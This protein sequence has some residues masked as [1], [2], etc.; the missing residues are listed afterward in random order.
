MKKS[1][2][3]LL[4]TM[5]D[6]RCAETALTTFLTVQSSTARSAMLA[7][8][9]GILKKYRLSKLNL[10]NCTAE[11]NRSGCIAIKPKKFITGSSCPG[12]NENLYSADSKVRI[13]S[14]CE[15]NTWDT[16]TYGCRCG[17]VFGKI[18]RT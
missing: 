11:I 3:Y 8:L 12:C 4:P 14:I 15:G 6:R 17:E 18:E 10:H 5:E 7:A 16:V 1:T 13:L 9:K 2:V